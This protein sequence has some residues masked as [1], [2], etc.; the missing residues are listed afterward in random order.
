MVLKTHKLR[1]IYIAVD[2]INTVLICIK[3]GLIQ[4]LGPNE[5]R[6]SALQ[7]R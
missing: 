3:A 6:H 1:E 7:S 5:C 2:K 4:C